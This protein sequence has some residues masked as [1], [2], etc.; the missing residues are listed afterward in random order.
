[1]ALISDAVDTDSVPAPGSA[2]AADD[3]FPALAGSSSDD[4]LIIKTIARN[5]NERLLL[6]R[7]RA[8]NFILLHLIYAASMF[9]MQVVVFHYF[10]TH[11][12]YAVE[13]DNVV[14]HNDFGILNSKTYPDQSVSQNHKISNH[15]TAIAVSISR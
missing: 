9:T 3:S 1:V 2:C 7:R 6:L 15:K 10:T 12:F 14:K 8:S 13:R 5:G 4:E 11:P